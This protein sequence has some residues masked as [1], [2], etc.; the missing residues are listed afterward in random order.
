M[1]KTKKILVAGFDPC[2]LPLFAETF[3]ELEPLGHEF[4]FVRFGL[5]DKYPW[6]IIFLPAAKF[7]WF[8]L[9]AGY[10]YRGKF[11]TLIC[12][13]EAAEKM[14][15]GAARILKIKKIWLVPPEEKLPA[16]ARG[17]KKWLKAA[18]QTSVLVFTS[19]DL[20]ERQN[21]GLP[22]ERLKLMTPAI[23]LHG[24][25]YQENIFYKIAQAESQTKKFFN[26]G[27][28]CDLDEK[29]LGDLEL[30]FQAIR[31]ARQVIPNLQ[32]IVVGDGEEKKKL[33]W[34]AKKLGLD[35]C[36][37]LVGEQPQLRKWLDSFDAFL[38]VQSRPTLNDYLLTLRAME[39]ELPVI[40]PGYLGFE[41]LIE[42]DRSGLITETGG[43]EALAGQI[44]RLKQDRRL[45]QKL[46]Q[47][48]RERVEKN[49]Q[50]EKTVAAFKEIL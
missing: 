32:L 41:D 1:E 19:K 20:I 35:A 38:A 29:R 18:E 11:D 31:L 36:L 34:L 25:K 33:L 48:A 22:A 14:T 9:L 50:L 21:A 17:R 46:G 27:F 12:C 39:A 30:I 26:L 7:F 5:K 2:R 37:W 10:K 24:Q 23:R 43:S 44:I 4:K 49:F 3:K 13:D 47:A 16:D 40:A 15:G 6:R 45:A 28:I 42:N 8:A